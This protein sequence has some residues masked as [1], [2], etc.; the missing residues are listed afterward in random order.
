[1]PYRAIAQAINLVVFIERTAE[2]RRVRSVTRVLGWDEDRYRL[3]DVT[4][5]TGL[6]ALLG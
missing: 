4:P 3:E 2:G 1:M 6:G 5:K